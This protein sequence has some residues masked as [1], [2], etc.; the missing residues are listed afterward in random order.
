MG[1]PIDTERAFRTPAELDDLVDAI[2]ESDGKTGH[3]SHWL[4]WK[5]P[6]LIDKTEGQFH[7]ARTILGF[8]N[9]DPESAARDCEG[10]A[11]L[12]AGAEPQSVPGIG[13]IDFADLG[14]GI[15][16]YVQGVRWAP[17]YVAHDQGTVLVIVVEAP[18]PGDPIHTLRKGTDKFH[19]GTIFHRGAARTAPA[20]PQDVSMLSTRLVAAFRAP[21]LALDLSAHAPNRLMRLDID[22]TAVDEWLAKREAHVRATVEKPGPPKPSTANPDSGLTGLSSAFI[23]EAL[24]RPSEQSM[25]DAAVEKY[26]MRCRKQLL[27]SIIRRIVSAELNVVTLRV[28][29]KS[30]DP[31]ADVVV[32]ARFPRGGV[33]I[34]TSP[35]DV[36]AMPD[37]PEWP[38][39]R[40]ALASMVGMQSVV[41][42]SA[43]AGTFPPSIS[44]YTFG[45]TRVN[46]D[47]E[48]YLEVVWPVGDL[49]AE[50][51]DALDVYMPLGMSAPEELV[52]EMTGRS[53]SHRG[54]ARGTSMLIADPADVW[55]IADWY[56]PSGDD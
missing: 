10:V 48:D 23:A 6:L 56:D 12:V 43:M 4:E 45:G 26:L 40:D 33:L 51:D 5:G 19:A 34:R 46:D 24:G 9:R 20:N 11:Y 36:I 14:Q 53:K 30:E 41:P 28:V 55:R 54:V 49:L 17:H 13:A 22:D 16:R 21:G 29:N 37:P 35:P 18:R 8:A 15:D 2:V 39:Q 3:E 38:S 50:S 27:S 47:N 32:K 31:I 44:P 1:L 25:F 52:V 7:I 42:L